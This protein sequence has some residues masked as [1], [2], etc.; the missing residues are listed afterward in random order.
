MQTNDKS[1]ASWLFRGILFASLA[2]VAIT[3]YHADYLRIP[4]VLGPIDLIGSFVL[5]FAGFL[6]SAICWKRVLM[7]SGTC[8]PYRVC[9]AGMGLSVFAKYIPGKIWTV[10]GRAMYVSEKTDS[11][12]GLL[13][14][15]SLRMQILAIWVGLGLGTVG[16]LGAERNRPWGYVTTS[17]WLLLMVVIFSRPVRQF[18]EACLRICFRWHLQIPRVSAL[19]TMKLLPRFILTWGFWALGFSFFAR[20]LLGNGVE[21]RIGLGF[22]LATTIGIVAVIF[23]GGV[24]VREGMLTAYLVAAGFSV[25]DATTVAVASR[26]WFFVGEAFFFLAG[27]RAHRLSLVA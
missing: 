19:A 16:L 1:A 7:A 6:N 14:V 9:I 4:N 25:A 18:V 10:G 20:A 13:M 26:L 24:G 27:I 11:R 12:L 22:P 21:W 5:L 17:A 23:P 2:G 15:A 3:L 8:V